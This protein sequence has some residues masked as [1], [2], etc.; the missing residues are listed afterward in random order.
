[1]SSRDVRIV[2]PRP[3]TRSRNYC[4][5][6]KAISITYSERVSATIVIQHAERMRHIILSLAPCLAQ[7][8]I[9]TLS[10]KQHDLK[11]IE[12]KPSVVIFSTNCDLKISYSKRTSATYYP[13][14]GFIFM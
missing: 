5:C 3:K 4:C 9:S 11:K 13:K 14:C 8:Y 2:C 12:H 1:M 10:H 6:R 7:P